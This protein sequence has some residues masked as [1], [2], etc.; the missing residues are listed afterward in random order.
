MLR[1]ANECLGQ[2]YAKRNEFRSDFHKV[3]NH[4]LTEDEFETGWQLLIDKYSVK[5]NPFLT[6][7]YEVRK[8]WAKPYFKGVF[9][10]KM[11]STQRSESANHMLKSYVPPGCAMH[12]F[13]KQYIRLQ[14]DRDTDE[15]YEEKMT[16][17]GGV[18]LKTKTLLERHASKI[19]T[20]AMFTQFGK[21]LYEASAY[22]VTE[23]EKDKLYVA[24][25]NQA[26]KREAWCRVSFKVQVVDNGR[27]FV[28]ECGNFE[29][30]GLLCCHALKVMEYLKVKEIPP[31]H[32]VKRWTRDARDVLPEHLQLYQRDK[33]AARS[34]TFRH[35]N[36]YVNAMELVRIGDANVAAYEKAMEILKNGIVT[37]TPLSLERDGLGLED[38]EGAK[39]RDR[40]SEGNAAY[41]SETE[42]AAPMR[43]S[44]LLAPMKNRKAGRPTTSRDK[45]PYEDISKRSRFCSICRSRG[46]KST[47]CPQR[48]DMPKKPRKE[49]RCS[50]CGLT[51][52]RKNA[53]SKH[54]ADVLRANG[55]V[56]M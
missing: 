50:Q 27:K 39:A 53:C 4:M 54:S 30:T 3:V 29:H 11:T 9:C 24:M 45:T 28:C 26:D 14:F 41:H 16:K 21:E 7:I 31:D 49:A 48:G 35:S 19:Y 2:L 13:V 56:I 20:R 42:S 51:G 46:H 36:L 10:A 6:Q 12:M 5:D 34:I 18:V 47:T 40:T 52:H 38:R 1:K 25:H 17:I 43:L 37:V 44:S 23:A 22:E 8:K 55:G 32:I 15:S 33:N